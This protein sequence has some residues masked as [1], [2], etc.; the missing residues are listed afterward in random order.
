MEIDTLLVQFK[1]SRY[2]GS[3]CICLCFHLNVLKTKRSRD[4]NMH[5]PPQKETEIVLQLS[6]IYTIPKIYVNGMKQVCLGKANKLV[7]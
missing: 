4:L 5:E 3:P 6:F 2:G 1:V 7:D